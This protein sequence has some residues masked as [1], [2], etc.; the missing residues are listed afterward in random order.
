M[1][2][3]GLAAIAVALILTSAGLPARANDA[4]EAELTG[5]PAS[6]SE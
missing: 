4:R 5:A 6:N 2:K 1:L 3:H